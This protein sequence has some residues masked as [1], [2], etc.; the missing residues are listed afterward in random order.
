MKTLVLIPVLFFLFQGCSFKSPE[1]KWEYNS[2]SAFSSYTK[3]FLTANDEIAKDDLNRAIKYSKQSANLDQLARVYLGKCSLNI[4]VGI[5]DYC[6]EYDEIKELV[7][8]VQ[9]NAYYSMLQNVLEKKQIKSLPKQYQE[10]SYYMNLKKHDLAF[11]SI[12]DMN[13]TSSKFVAASIMKK[14][15]KKSQVEY[16]INE[17]S[18]YGFKKNVLFW[19]EHLSMIETNLD[20]IKRIEK[21]LKI[22]KN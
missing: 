22:L 11:E 17:A 9:L 14:H 7:S 16:L 21:K 2:A 5:K 4:S 13:Q 15:L 12:K 8:S 19:L 6:K 20:E 10:F 18:F 3:N 1:N